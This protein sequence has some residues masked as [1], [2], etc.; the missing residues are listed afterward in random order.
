MG[1]NFFNLDLTTTGAHNVCMGIPPKTT[2]KPITGLNATPGCFSMVFT[3]WATPHNHVS[4]LAYGPPTKTSHLVD[5]RGLEPRSE[6]PES[7]MLPL[8]HGSVL[9][10]RVDLNHRPVSY[11]D[12]TLPRLNTT[13]GSMV[14]FDIGSS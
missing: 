5:P 4:M 6:E 13:L 3:G 14:V 1:V 2:S 12:T 7:S 9:L 8:H 11:Q 10:G